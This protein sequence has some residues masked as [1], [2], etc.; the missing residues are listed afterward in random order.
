MGRY[1]GVPI[2]KDNKGRRYLKGVKYPEIPVSDS[3]TYIISTWGDS[4][5]LLSYD[6]YN[7]VNDYWIIIVANDLPGDSRFIAPG[8]QVRIPKDTIPIK[9]EFN[10][11]NGID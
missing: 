5:D 9:A 6:Y 10:R 11:L 8:T 2:L 4:V 7:T 3:D 1:D